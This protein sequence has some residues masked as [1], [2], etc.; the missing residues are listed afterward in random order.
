MTRPQIEDILPLSSLQRGLLFHSLYDAEGLDLYT[1]QFHVEL[2]GEV[3]RTA[4][5]SAANTLLRRHS[6]LR[7]MFV[8]E[9][10]D[11]PVQVV[12]SG[13][14]VPWDEIDLSD[15]DSVAADA[16]FAARHDAERMRRFVLDEDVLVRCVLY[17]LPDRVFRL[18]LT[19]HHILLDGWSVPVLLEELFELYERR[20]GTAGMPVVTPYREYLDWIGRQDT[21]A[22]T[23][24]WQELLH[25][26]EATRIVPAD[27]GGEPRPPRAVSLELPAEVTAA[28]TEQARDRG[29]TLNTA[30]QAAWG[31][32]LGRL[33]GRTDVLFGGTVSGR[34]AELPGVERMIGLLIN[35]LPVRVGWTGQDSLADLVSSVQRQQ[36]ALLPHQHV[37]LAELHRLRGD[38]ELFDTTLVYENY[39]SGADEEQVLSGGVRITDVHGRDST[40][41]AVTV[42]AMPGDRLRFRLDYRP[43][44]LDEA[45]VRRLGDWLERT[46]R[47]LAARADDPV[48]SVE[49]ITGAEREQVLRT[50]NDTAHPVPEDTLAGLLARQAA[51]TPGA[52]ALVDGDTELTYAELHERVN[53]LARRLIAAGAGPE[54]LVAVALPRSTELVVSLLAV[55]TSGAAYLPIAPEHPAERVAMML[56]DARPVCVLAQSATALAGAGGMPVLLPGDVGEGSPEAITDA[57]RLAPLDPRSPAY[58][59][60]TSGSTGT[61][62]GVAV[63]H[64]G[65]VNRLAWMQAE[66]GLTDDDRV[67]QKTPFGFDVSV[68]EFFWPL[69]TGA[70]LVVAEPEGHKDPAYL[71]GLIRTQR[72]TTV[73]FVPS[74][75]EVFLAE[76]AAADCAAG[77]RRVICSGEAL[78]PATAD[79]C[80]KVLGTE[81]HN[82]YGPTEA[83]VDVTYWQCLP[84]ASSVPIGA[85]VWNT[86]TYVLDARLVPVPPGVPGELYL[87]GAQ[88]ARGYVGR[89][90]LSAERFVANPHGAP[91][92]RM[93]R[94]GDLAWWHEDGTLA[95]AGRVD[96]QVKI[97]GQR[98][99]PGEIQ[100]VLAHHPG[101]AQVAVVVREDRPGDQRLAAYVVPAG[102]RAP[103]DGELGEY[104]GARL[105][106]HMVPGTFTTL[107][108]LP[109]SP[110][111]KLDRRAL[112][113]P[114]VAA[115][116]G[117]GSR[118]MT[119]ELL[120]R[121][122][123]EVL[124][125][126]RVGPEDGFFELGGHSLLA[127]RLVDRIGSLLG[128]SSTVRTVFEAP[129]AAALAGR[130]A[131]QDAGDD[132]MATLLPLRRNGDLPPLFCVHP[133]GGLSW[134]YAGLL[135]ELDPAIP[136][137]GLQSPE[138]VEGG[139]E[140][141][142][143]QRAAGFV[144]RIRT[145]RPEGPYRLLGWS[146]GGHIA[147]EMAVQL[148]RQGAEVDLL[149]TLDAYP[150]RPDDRLDRERI[151]ADMFAATDVVRSDMDT[152]PGRAKVF[153]TVRAGLSGHDWITDEVAGNVL[154]SYLS[155]TL[156]MQAASPGRFEGDLMFFRAKDI[157]GDGSRDTE[158]WRPHVQG[159][160]E[161]HQMEQVHED[162]A[163]RDVL[164]LVAAAVN[165]AVITDEEE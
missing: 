37:D 105:P 42:V 107:D 158:L 152:E 39:P 29:W 123:A 73:H 99:E 3:D 121:A 78:S 44:S 148:Q 15:M 149:V 60:Y 26:A 130:L 11:E 154:E 91:G 155:T 63:P 113:V 22:A 98:I 32:V 134:C 92:E 14:E 24:A 142:I 67:L 116:T 45:A 89:A 82:L 72:V 57:D 65:I 17:V 51:R 135:G 160:I 10:F 46:L 4:L 122:I 129:T 90:A 86:R 70:A 139:S 28:L 126:D 125:L 41:Y 100:A 162:M 2:R 50:W 96:D 55:V 138:V 81:L 85:P 31:L 115:G 156:A 146:A 21:E 159:R 165:D 143:A 111:G 19:L 64:S 34:P 157:V 30:V 161:V 23:S 20:G 118:T 47:A 109:V 48:D 36:S 7:A 5:R 68:W 54:R 53:R 56:G 141:S 95:Y 93:Y 62:K 153:E 114:E 108:T 61:P 94:T 127:I 150:A 76:P 124:G 33:T 112:P 87:A 1:V 120:C 58:V 38:G 80:L 43:E 97:R 35:T 133:A 144:E 59:I 12:R 128:V 136:V 69:I 84:A 66:Y 18:G 147:H 103:S 9:G 140:A 77:L 145:L 88:L 6:N 102:G 137:Y 52:T 83:S 132:A 25:G 16:E 79:T 75:L 110:N 119:E 104:A 164:D 8:H 131:G 13:V 40:H 27:R 74:M 101:L 106:A 151:F 117:R 163:R 71:A 49:L